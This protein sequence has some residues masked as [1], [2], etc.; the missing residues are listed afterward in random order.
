MVCRNQGGCFNWINWANH[1]LVLSATLDF[2]LL[3]LRADGCIKFLHLQSGDRRV[4]CNCFIGSFYHIRKCTATPYSP[5]KVWD[6]CG[7][8]Q[9]W[10]Q[11]LYRALLILALRTSSSFPILWVE[12]K[13]FLWVWWLGWCRFSLCNE[14]A[15]SSSWRW[16]E[17][18]VWSY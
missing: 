3:D 12:Q 5:T 14:N 2:M 16:M 18:L 17:M 7:N 8:C 6:F 15:V 1:S 9:P 4:G 10:S 13:V 11:T